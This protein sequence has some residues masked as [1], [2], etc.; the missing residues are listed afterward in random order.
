MREDMKY[1]PCYYQ[2]R[3]YMVNTMQKIIAGNKT[4]QPH[5]VVFF[6]DSIT[7]WNP[8]KTYYPEIVNKYN[9]GICGATSE[10][11]RWI[12]DEAVIKYKPSV[13]VMLMG[14]NDLSNTDAR[15]PRQIACNVKIIIELITK[16]LPGVKLLLME[17]LPCDEHREGKFAGKYMRSNGNICLLNREYQELT[18][19]FTNVKIVHTYKAFWDEN[20]KGI[21]KDFTTDGLHL[22]EKGYQCLAD[23]LKPVLLDSIK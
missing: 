20:N 16:N 9:C 15:S 7:E 22:T 3:D 18:K 10:S 2:L 14:T 17:T 5:G 12:C 11:L 19:Q 8:I 23:Q 4:A 13:V 21:Y 6:G 1:N